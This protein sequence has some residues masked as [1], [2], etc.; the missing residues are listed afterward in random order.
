M[1]ELRL[2]TCAVAGEW[3][4]A[5]LPHT[6]SHASLLESVMKGCNSGIKKGDHERS[7]FQMFEVV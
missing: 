6:K 1:T 7:D 5:D 2:V 4:G 3:G